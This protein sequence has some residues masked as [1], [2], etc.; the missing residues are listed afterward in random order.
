LKDELRWADMTSSA[1]PSAA[2][3]PE[4]DDRTDGLDF[5]PTAPPSTGNTSE[6][7]RAQF[8]DLWPESFELSNGDARP[9]VRAAEPLWPIVFLSLALLAMWQLVRSR[10]FASHGPSFANVEQRK[11]WVRDG[12]RKNIRTVA[13]GTT[14]A[15][16]W[17]GGMTLVVTYLLDFI[18]GAPRNDLFLIGG[19]LAA[20]GTVAL[21]RAVPE[22]LGDPKKPPAQSYSLAT[23]PLASQ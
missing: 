2:G 21:A 6:E 1:S 15:A 11:F 17:G 20:F 12:R 8:A 13:Y 23:Q 16:M 5:G 3:P 22:L 18:D 4:T 19:M 14:F 9:D 7:W 10:A